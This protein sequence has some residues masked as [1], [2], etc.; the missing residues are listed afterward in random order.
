VS[1]GESVKVW[2]DAWFAQQNGFKIWTPPKVLAEDATVRDLT[3]DNGMEWN[4][5]LVDSIFL[6]FQGS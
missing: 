1:K 3:A 6:P 5:D 2:K 4:N